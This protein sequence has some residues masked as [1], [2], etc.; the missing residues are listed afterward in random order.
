MTCRLRVAFVL[1]A[2]AIA[3]CTVTA[4]RTR[5]ESGQDSGSRTMVAIPLP[6][7]APPG[8]VVLFSGKSDQF[9]SGWIRRYTTEPANWTVDSSGVAT[10]QK[11]DIATKQ[12]FGD[13]YLHV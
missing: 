6:T 12:E 9:K 1:V 5:A 7:Q 4:S 11:S 2:F 13:S 8:A 3:G 10:P